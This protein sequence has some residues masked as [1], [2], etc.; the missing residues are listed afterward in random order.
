MRISITPNT[1]TFHA[2]SFA[3]KVKS[4]SSSAYPILMNYFLKL[5]ELLCNYYKKSIQEDKNLKT[6]MHKI[7][8]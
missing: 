3:Q 2:V 6:Q 8:N 7:L 4:S 5:P 1:D